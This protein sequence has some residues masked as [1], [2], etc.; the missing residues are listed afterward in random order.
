[1]GLRPVGRRYCLGSD[2][3]LRLGI[4]FWFRLFNVAPETT[5][6]FFRVEHQ[7]RSRSPPCQCAGLSIVPDG[8]ELKATAGSSKGYNALKWVRYARFTMVDSDDSGGS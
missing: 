1:M 3:E 2:C 4:C 5:A 7:S 6:R 8:R